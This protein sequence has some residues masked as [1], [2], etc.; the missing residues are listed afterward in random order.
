MDHPSEQDPGFL[1]MRIVFKL[2]GPAKLGETNMLPTRG[3]IADFMSEKWSWEDGP[4]LC[5]FSLSKFRDFAATYVS[6]MPPAWIADD[7]SCWHNALAFAVDHILD[8][9]SE[10][11]GLT[12][13]V[14]FV[15]V[16][17][18]WRFGQAYTLDVAELS[19][20][21]RACLEED[22]KGKELFSRLETMS[23]LSAPGHNGFK[24]QGGRGD[25]PPGVEVGTWR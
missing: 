1:L 21:T 20:E 8:N 25:E 23:I 19:P 10:N 9:P 6:P 5:S 3:V 22:P 11:D 4:E 7:A 13:T 14:T 15:P 24:I 17:D 12:P 2:N 16:Q 18:G